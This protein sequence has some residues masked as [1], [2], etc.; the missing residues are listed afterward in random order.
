MACI[1]AGK[2][3]ARPD[4]SVPADLR[5]RGPEYRDACGEKL[6]LFRPLS[7]VVTSVLQY[8]LL[9]MRGCEGGRHALDM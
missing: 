7:S 9:F 5:S 3:G 8:R 1:R 2:R 4:L 6:I